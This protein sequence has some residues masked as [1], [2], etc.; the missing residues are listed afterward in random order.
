MKVLLV[1]NYVQLRQQ[2]MQKFAEMM[3]R[4]LEEQGHSVRLIRPPVVF[5]KLWPGDT[6][7]AKWIGY[8]DR[9]VLF[10]FFLRKNLKW[11]HVMHVCDQANA[12]YLARFDGP[13]VLT[14]HDLFAVRSALGRIDE[15]PTGFTGKILQRWV[16]SQLKLAPSVICVSEQTSTELQDV[17]RLPKD[18]VRVI[19]NALNYQYV[20][21]AAE[22]ATRALAELGVTTASPFFVHVGGN[23]WYK[24]R[25]GVL[26]VF[27]ELRDHATFRE[28]RL[29]MAGQPF[30][31]E[32]REFISRHQLEAWVVERTGVTDEQLRA[33]YSSASALLFPSL[34]EGFGWPIVEA[35]A[36]GCP[37]VTT[38][39]QPMIE[40]SGGE[41]ILIDPS[42]PSGSA[43][44]ILE[45]WGSRESLASRGLVN[46]ARFGLQ[47]M[48]ERYVA[49][50]DDARIAESGKC[51][52]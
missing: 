18:R 8:L 38:N 17:A 51:A 22:D 21:M 19:E 31:S 50:Y 37:V 49:A 14:C 39:K 30:T 24:N 33:L 48:I 25:L 12:M 5:G 35:Q 13:K 1:G 9:F 46:S 27:A 32:M 42:D 7:L 28:H 43:A 15:N 16:L 29:V 45:A 20:R 36:C 6:G 3:R 44:R 4:G 10:P 34:Q 41:A 40:V 52:V 26:K 47:G 2:S 11:A 23:A